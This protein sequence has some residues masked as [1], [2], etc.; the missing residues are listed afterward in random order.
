MLT[1]YLSLVDTPEEK[2]KVE[3]IYLEYKHLI[4]HLALSKLHDD[5]LADEVVHDVMIVIIDNL[6][7]LEDRDEIGLKNF[8]YH[9]TRNICIN[10]YRKEQRHAAITLDEPQ[11]AEKSIG[12]PQDSLGEKIVISCITK[13]TP[14]YREILELTACYGF[15]VKEC[16]KILNISPSAVQKRLERAR[17]IIRT[18]L[19][20]ED[21][22]V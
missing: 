8:I 9:V 14:I 19:K 20:E 18:K 21:L 11:I 4:K 10:V 15:T 7:K 3:E 2:T 6:K 13:M 16:S 17:A 1:Y 22:Y 5:Q 12:D